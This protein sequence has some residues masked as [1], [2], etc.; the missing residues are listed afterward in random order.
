[1]LTD[2]RKKVLKLNQTLR[3][4]PVTIAFKRLR[5]EDRESLTCLGYMVRDCLRKQKQ[6]SGTQLILNTFIESRAQNS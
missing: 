3:Q 4:R 6:N 2:T 5:Q 1:M